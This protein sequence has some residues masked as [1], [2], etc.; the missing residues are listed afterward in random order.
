ME[1]LTELYAATLSDKNICYLLASVLHSS[2]FSARKV[3]YVYDL[4]SKE[5][6]LANFAASHFQ[7]IVFPKMLRLLHFSKHG[8]FLRVHFSLV[9][10]HPSRITYCGTHDRI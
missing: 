1:I 10:A 8:P 5:C 4:M 6:L 3:C 2:Q 9:F 7:E